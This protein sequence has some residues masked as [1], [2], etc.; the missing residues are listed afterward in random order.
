MRSFDTFPPQVFAFPAKCVLPPSACI[1]IAT[2]V[3][4][5]SRSMPCYHDGVLMYRVFMQAPA[6]AGSLLWKR[7]AEWP[8]GKTI[9]SLKDGVGIT[10]TRAT[11]TK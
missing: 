4:V 8:V 5:C 6:A 7:G 2:K 3:S 11:V 1:T 9:V 10:L